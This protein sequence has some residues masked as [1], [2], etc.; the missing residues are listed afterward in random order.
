MWRSATRSPRTATKGFG[1]RDAPAGLPRRTNPRGAIQPDGTFTAEH[2]RGEP[3][4]DVTAILTADHKDVNAPHA[5][6]AVAADADTERAAIRAE[7]AGRLPQM[8]RT[9]CRSCWIEVEDEAR[10]RSNPS[11]RH[12]KAVRATPPTAG[13]NG[14]SRRVSCTKASG[15]AV[16]GWPELKIRGIMGDHWISLHAGIFV[17]GRPRLRLGI[18]VRPSPHPRPVRGPRIGRA[19]CLPAGFYGLC[20]MPPRRTVADGPQFRRRSLRREAVAGGRGPNAGRGFDLGRDA[21]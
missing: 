14:A 4:S 1:S 9:L 15:Y 17:R 21:G 8:S 12:P 7:E 3:T 11:P 5:D 13:K 2:P 16:A 20:V 10:L 19:A 6:D 18:F